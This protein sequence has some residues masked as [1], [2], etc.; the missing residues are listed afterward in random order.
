[1]ISRTKYD[2]GTRT[3]KAWPEERTRTSNYK[4]NALPIV[5]DTS[6]VRIKTR[7]MKVGRIYIF[8]KISD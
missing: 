5:A 2:A 1:M 3:N 7:C 8:L 4:F 6:T